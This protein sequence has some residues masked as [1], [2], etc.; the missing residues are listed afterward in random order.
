MLLR[1]WRKISDNGDRGFTQNFAARL[2]SIVACSGESFLKKNAKIKKSTLFENG[3]VL[4]F[5]KCQFS[6]NKSPC[7]SFR[8]GLYLFRIYLQVEKVQKSEIEILILHNSTFETIT[9]DHNRSIH[10]LMTWSTF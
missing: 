6:R 9:F 1:S 7:G 10:T 8:L 5:R 3:D 4:K 2:V